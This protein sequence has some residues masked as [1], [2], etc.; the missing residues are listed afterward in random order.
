[1]HNQYTYVA[2]ILLQ[3]TRYNRMLIYSVD[4]VPGM[5]FLRRKKLLSAEQLHLGSESSACKTN[6]HSSAGSRP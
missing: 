2:C 4:Q 3:I 6:I 5:C 1:M